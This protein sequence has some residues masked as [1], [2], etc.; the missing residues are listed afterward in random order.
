MAEGQEKQPVYLQYP[1]TLTINKS[2]RD[3]P[4]NVRIKYTNKNK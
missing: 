2:I 3:Y 4:G 1:P